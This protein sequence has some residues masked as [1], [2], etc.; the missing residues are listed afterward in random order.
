MMMMMMVVV[1]MKEGEEKRG[2]EREANTRANGDLLE[3]L[4]SWR[5]A[6]GN[7]FGGVWLAAGRQLM[8][9]RGGDMGRGLCLTRGKLRRRGQVLY[10]PGM[11]NKEVS[12][13]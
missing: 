1:M 7:V 12:V 8:H 13:N 11:V 2:E 4:G 6:A 3:V 9:K 10:R 5:L